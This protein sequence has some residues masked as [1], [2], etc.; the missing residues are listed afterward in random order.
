MWFRPFVLVRI[1]ISAFCLLGCAML[2][3]GVGAFGGLVLLGMLAFLVFVSIC[4][5]QF[6]E[7]ALRL[8]VWLF[9]LE[10]VGGVVIM[11][12]ENYLGF[13]EFSL[14]TAAAMRGLSVW[15]GFCRTR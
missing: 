1:P 7:D 15:S 5:F 4:L 13:R 2:L 10:L 3:Q 9:L 8:A 11:A 6:H 12:G 14:L